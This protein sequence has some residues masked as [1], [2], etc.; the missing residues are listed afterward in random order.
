MNHKELLEK[1]LERYKRLFS[2][3]TGTLIITRTSTW[4]T[5][6]S[7]YIPLEDH[8]LPRQ[9]KKYMDSTIKRLE[10]VWDNR[11]I[12]DDLLPSINPFYGIAEHSSF[13]GGCVSYGGDTSYHHPILESLD[14]ISTLEIEENNPHY[15]MLLDSMTY[16][17]E[18][19]HETNLVPSLRGAESP[20][21]IA[22]AIRGNNLFL[23]MYDREND[24]HSLLN[25]CSDALLWNL[26]N[27]ISRVDAIDG[28]LITGFGIWMPGRSVGHISEDTSSMCS[29][30]MYERYGLPY[31]QKVL[32]HYEGVLVHIH[33]LGAHILPQL[34]SMKNLLVVQIEADPNQPTPLEIFKSNEKIFRDKIIM[35]RL[36]AKEYYDNRDFLQDKRTILQIAPSSM[37]EAQEL[38]SCVRAMHK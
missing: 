29:S 5:E 19:K 13:F 4:G 6:Q 30:D 38:V 35:M 32:D 8:D 27:Q 7:G 1:K 9:W 14:E 18:C 37:D 20:L 22:N 15:K 34:C 23:D 28:G 31:S 11:T 25:K 2:S 21:D 26:E 17:Q 24:V 16:L 3:E 36:D 12:D 33:G 10:S